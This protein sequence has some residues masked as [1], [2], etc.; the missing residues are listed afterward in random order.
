VQQPSRK[1]AR[2]ASRV[3]PGQQH[4]KQGVWSAGPGVEAVLQGTKAQRI[5]NRV[6]REHKAQASLGAVSGVWRVRGAVRS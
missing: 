2:G 4:S 6:W 1:T 5:Q 3:L